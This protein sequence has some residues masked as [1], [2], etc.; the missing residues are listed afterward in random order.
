MRAAPH[1][2]RVQAVRLPVGELRVLLGCHACL[3]QAEVEVPVCWSG[4]PHERPRLDLDSSQV[5]VWQQ[6]H[7]EPWAAVP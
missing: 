2:P 5:H 1:R 3:Q 4:N 7:R 6:A